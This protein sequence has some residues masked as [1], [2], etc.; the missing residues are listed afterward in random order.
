M[1]NL[2]VILCFFHYVVR[3]SKACITELHG[4][5]YAIFVDN[6]IKSGQF[7]HERPNFEILSNFEKEILF[8]SLN[9]FYLKVLLNFTTLDCIFL[10]FVLSHIHLCVV[11]LQEVRKMIFALLFNIQNN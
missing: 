6:E 4:E 1:Q 8:D 2:K 11:A 9:E 5:L 3:L 10:I 7:F